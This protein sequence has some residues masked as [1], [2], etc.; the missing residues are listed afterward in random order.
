MSRPEFISNVHME[1]LNKLW[2]GKK[3][4]MF[5]ADRYVRKEFSVSKQEAKGILK[6]WFEESLKNYPKTFSHPQ[7]DY[8][9]LDGSLNVKQIIIEIISVISIFAWGG[10]MGFA[11]L[12]GFIIKLK[13]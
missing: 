5:R 3:T 9:Y 11:I 1:Y 2:D 7:G 6:Y 12:S 4:N 13:I 8:R 10:A